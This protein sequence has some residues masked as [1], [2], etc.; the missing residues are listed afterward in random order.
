MWV[1][2][3]IFFFIVKCPSSPRCPSLLR[4]L[5]LLQGHEDILYLLLCLLKVLYLSL[6]RDAIAFV[7]ISNGSENSEWPDSIFILFLQ[8]TAAAK[9]LQSRLTLCDPIDGNPPCSPVLGILQARILERVAIS[10]SNAWKWKVK[11]E[12]E[13]VPKGREYKIPRSGRRLIL[14]AQLCL[15]LCD[16]VDPSWPGSSVHRTS[17]AGILEQIAV[18]SSGDLPD[19][20]IE[21]MSYASPVLQE[22][23]LLLAFDRV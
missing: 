9:S 5:S 18:S 19:F 22:D 2:L 14:C 11:S 21:P 12:S 10:S 1:D 16:P 8:K 6:G 17:Q 4:M 20:G 23:S 13:V 7:R 3:W 15:T